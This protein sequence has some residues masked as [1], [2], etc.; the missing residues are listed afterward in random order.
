MSTRTTTCE[1]CGTTN[2]V[3]EKNDDFCFECG[4]FLP[5]P[6]PEKDFTTDLGEFVRA[7]VSAQERERRTHQMLCAYENEIRWIRREIKNTLPLLVRRPGLTAKIDELRH[8][9]R[10][11]EICMAFLSSDAQEI[12]HAG[13]TRG[14]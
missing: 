11:R 14:G 4:G 3:P 10:H 6:E 7:F 5:R 9:I 1:T 13:N 12:A 2:T 8:Q